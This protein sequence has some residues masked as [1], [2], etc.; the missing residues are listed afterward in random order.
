MKVADWEKV[1]AVFKQGGTSLVVQ[2]LRHYP[3]DAGGPG[4]VL[5]QRTRS[6]MWQQRLKIQ[7]EA[8]KTQ[9]SQINK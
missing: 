4:S 2:W 9:S 6:C 7:C 5:G 8:A 3:L 1:S